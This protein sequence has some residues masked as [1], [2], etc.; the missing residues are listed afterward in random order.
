MN[1]FTN[2]DILLR[3]QLAMKRQEH[4]D[5]GQAIDALMKSAPVDQLQLRRLKKQKLGLKD[6]IQILE[7]KLFPNLIA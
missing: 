2:I 5:L 1:D 7:A 4:V 3:E 6:Q